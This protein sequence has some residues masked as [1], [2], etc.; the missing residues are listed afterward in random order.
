MSKQQGAVHFDDQSFKDAL[1]QDKP[2][3]VDFF[4]EW[5]GPCQMAAPIIDK[6]ADEYADK[7]VIAKLNVDENP[8]SAQEYGVMS[9]PTVLI[10]K[11]DG[12]ESKIVGRQVGFPGEAG[13]KAMIEEVL[14][15]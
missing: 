6:L 7:I 3:F 4:A 1:K 14:G 12:G 9:I 15:K 10:F 5:C 2:V 13:Y 8:T 11:N